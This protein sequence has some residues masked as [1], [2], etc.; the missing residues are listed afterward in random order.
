MKLNKHIVNCSVHINFGEIS[1]MIFGI[2]FSKSFK[3][4]LILASFYFSLLSTK[5]KI[6]LEIFSTCFKSNSFGLF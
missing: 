6:N 5:Y 4:M 2:F 3:F 1:F